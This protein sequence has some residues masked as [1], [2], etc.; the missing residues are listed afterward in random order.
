MSTGIH[1]SAPVA[2]TATV[3]LAGQDDLSILT[4]TVALVCGIWFFFIILVQAIGSIQLYVDCVL[5]AESLS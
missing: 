4:Y 3:V 2:T 5:K 1:N